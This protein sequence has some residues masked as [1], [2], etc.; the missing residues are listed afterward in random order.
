MNDQQFARSNQESGFNSQPIYGRFSLI[1][2]FTMLVTLLPHY[3]E[4]VSPTTTV[5]IEFIVHGILYLGWYILSAIQTRLVST[6]NIS[7][8][9][10]LG[11]LSLLLVC[12]LTY[13]G[14]A[15]MIGVMQSF[16]SSWS[17]AFLLS[18]TSFVLAI[19]HTLLSFT[20]FYAIALVY[21]KNSHAHKR[22]MILASLSMIAASIT[23]IAYLPFIPVDGFVVVLL[24]TYGFLIVP[25]VVDRKVFGVIHPVLKWGIPVY[26]VSQIVCIGILPSTELGQAIAFPF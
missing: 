4:I 21:R 11:Y 14:T 20:V 1:L 16:D 2:I 13:S 6:R 22:F 19:L 5:T 12:M 24:V 3:G 17:S 15:M 9:K 26:L 8:H 23:R 25:V 7:L 10:K 18:R